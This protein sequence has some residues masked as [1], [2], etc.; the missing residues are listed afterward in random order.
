M[1]G[2][3]VVVNVMLSRGVDT[4]FFVPGGTNTTIMESLSR[5]QNKI[6]AIPTRLESSAAFACDTYSK[7]KKKPACMLASRAPGACNATVGIHNAMQASRPLVFFISNIPKPQQGREAFQEINYHL[8][9]KPIAKAVFDV[10]SFDEL[11]DV[12]ARALDLSISGR[13]GP[14]VVAVS[15]DILDG[16]E[17][18]P[19]IP[20]VPAAVRVGADADAIDDAVTMIN[21]AKH[22]I[23][24]S[25]EMVS[26]ESAFEELK[27]FADASGV[28]V[29]TA[30]RQQDTFPSDH[31][32]NYGHLSINRLPFQNEALEDCDLLISVGCRLDS[33]T[34]DDYKMIRPDQ[35]LIM[36]YPEPSEFSQY[37]S[38][39][40]IGSNVI[41][42]LKALTEKLS[43]PPKERLAWR[44]KIHGAEA[45]F[46]KPGEI[47]IQGDV[48]MAQ[49]IQE[50][51][52]QVPEDC[53]NIC[54]A[55][56]FGRW[57]GRYYRFNQ[58]DIESSPV[59][60]SM[61]YGVPGG[62]GAQIA[63]PDSTVFVWVGDGGFTMTGHECAAIMQAKLPVKVIVCDNSAW[64]SI[65]T[66]QQKRFGPDFNYGTMLDS[67]DF[68]KLGEGYGMASFKVE[69]TDQFAG[70]LAGAMAHDGAAMI[71]LV[72]DSRDV[73]PYT[74]SA[75]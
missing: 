8:M 54:D 7:F 17:G 53:I 27:D 38:D 21:A 36:I 70:A 66:H 62:I 44:D 40:A 29:L 49:V 47:E 37:Q 43:P 60:G 50:F 5:N 16:P 69:N 46:A 25:G 63:K 42:A 41:P 61:G 71:H 39:V 28:G 14:V 74:G 30:Y 3:E 64:G 24:I 10:H 15:K 20:D 51:I 67:P 4:V 19:L 52:K 22:P 34:V 73:S 31:P 58:P 59:S 1:N 55:G 18:E 13:P 35:K 2:G 45:N 6:Q 48:D 72:L 68:A 23:V 12:T 33:V 75:R 65:L 32:A 26:W 9:Y 57:I 56:T 11:A